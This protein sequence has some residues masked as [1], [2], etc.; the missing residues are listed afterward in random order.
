MWLEVEDLGVQLR[1]PSKG[2]TLGI[3]NLSLLVEGFHIGGETI[4]ILKGR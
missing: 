4:C 2:S 1:L 3:Q